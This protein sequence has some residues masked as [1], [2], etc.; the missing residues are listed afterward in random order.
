MKGLQ[1]IVIGLG[2]IFCYLSLAGIGDS[3]IFQPDKKA[4]FNKC[5]AASNKGFRTINRNIRR[6]KERVRFYYQEK[7]GAKVHNIPNL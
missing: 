4:Y 7:V 1:Y 6:S 2:L 3:L 5:Q